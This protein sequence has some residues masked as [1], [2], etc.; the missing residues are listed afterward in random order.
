MAAYRLARREPPKC[1]NPALQPLPGEQPLAADC[2][3]S[4]NIW[5]ALIGVSRLGHYTRN[6]H[7]L[8]CLFCHSCSI[9][10]GKLDIMPD[11]NI[12]ELPAT[13]LLQLFRTRD[14]SPLELMQAIISRSEQIEPNIN[15]FAD[16]YFEEALVQAKQAEKQYAT[17]AREAAT[18]AG[19]PL[20]VKDDTAIAGK[21][22]ASG[23]LMHE[24]HTDNHTNPSVQRLVDAGA[25]VHAR[26]TCP[27]FCW[28]WVCY[29]R[30]Y[31]VTRNP[32]N[33]DYTCGGSSGGS[34]AALAAGST[35]LATGTD[36]A[37]SIRQPAAMCGV[38]GFK[39]PYGRNPQQAGA[40]FDVY[41]HIGPMTRTV[42]DCALMQNAISG[43]HPL[44]HASVRDQIHIP[45]KLEGVKGMKIAW[46]ADLGCYEISPGVQRETHATIDALKEAGALVEEIDT[47]WAADAIAASGHYGDHLNQPVFEQA[48]NDFP[49]QLCDY[50]PYFAK[51][52]L[53]VTADQFRQ[54][55]TVAGEVWRDHFGPLLERYDAF[56]C[57]TTTVQE[58]PADMKP[59]DNLEVNGQ[60]IE[61]NHT[62]LTILFNM[63]SRCPVLAVPS[64][65]TDG[66]MPTGVQIIG[67]PF[68][69]ITPFRIGAAIESIRPWPLTAG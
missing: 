69:D 11:T 52:V 62:T 55:H 51:Q 15:A 46:S 22:S 39:P 54:A 35:V 12:V 64:G 34:A 31:G 4:W 1:P 58:I 65:K 13:R 29:S 44:D 49:Q 47:H 16:R 40:S 63:F 21:R 6:N 57:P 38:V 53:S 41:N 37:G 9:A 30:L 24:E 20:A 60:Q 14:L 68:D 28:A 2:A 18:L 10:H 43:Q 59:W 17:P 27:E 25:I 26:T 36:S 66:G 23:S 5:E 61:I 42:G 19:L 50:T 56:V 45:E 8:R 48:V 32:W 33:T 67:R 7:R 3:L